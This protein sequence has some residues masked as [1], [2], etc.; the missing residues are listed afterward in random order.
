M[1]KYTITI[2]VDPSDQTEFEDAVPALIEFGWP[3]RMHSPAEK[4]LDISAEIT[5]VARHAE[6]ERIWN[7][8]D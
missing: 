7:P 8:D 2:A 6:K 5:K 3:I 1:P 4:G